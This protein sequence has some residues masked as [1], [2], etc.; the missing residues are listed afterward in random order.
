MSVMSTGRRFVDSL[1]MDGFVDPGRQAYRKRRI[2]GEVHAQEAFS[3]VIPF[4]A[5][6][7]SLQA[8]GHDGFRPRASRKS[9]TD[10]EMV[11]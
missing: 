3:S 4:E 5:M 10:D 6:R 9:K 1:K 11:Q 7:A 8:E 2:V